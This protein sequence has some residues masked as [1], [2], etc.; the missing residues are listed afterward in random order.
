M[1]SATAW[2]VTGTFNVS[3]DK[4][5]IERPALLLVKIADAC[6]MALDLTLAGAK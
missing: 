1:T 2:H 3:L 5:S 4:Y 6:E